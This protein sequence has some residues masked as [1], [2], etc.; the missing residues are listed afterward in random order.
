MDYWFPQPVC[1]R[2]GGKII[3]LGNFVVHF[4]IEGWTPEE[5]RRNHEEWFPE[6]QDWRLVGYE[7]GLKGKVCLGFY[8]REKSFTPISLKEIIESTNPGKPFP[9]GF[10]I[11]NERQLTIIAWGSSSWLKEKEIW[12]ER[13]GQCLKEGRIK[14]VDLYEDVFLAL[15]KRLASLISFG[16]VYQT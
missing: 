3:A 2:K 5:I 6:Y 10:V 7:I 9:I 4:P 1:K 8:L 14:I 16:R 15:F 11:A 12:R 13:L